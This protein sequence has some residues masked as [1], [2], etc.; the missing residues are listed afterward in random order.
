MGHGAYNSHEISSE[1]EKVAW[2][3]A[4]FGGAFT[5]ISLALWL[6]WPKKEIVVKEVPREVLREV[7]REVPIEIIK[8]IVKP[9]EPKPEESFEANPNPLSYTR[10]VTVTVF[11]DQDFKEIMQATSLQMKAELKLRSLG[12]HVDNKTAGMGL[13]ELQISISALWT[14]ES[15]LQCVWSC[16]ADFQDMVSRLRITPDKVAHKQL[17]RA[18]TWSKGTFGIS[19]KNKIHDTFLGAVE[20][21]IDHFA[22]AYLEAN[23]K[24]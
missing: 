6:W 18:T 24:K 15:K 9:P 17:L 21:S 22:N 23:P 14:D 10:G 20:A 1:R 4:C 11:L 8:E 13:H 12:I 19:G 7:V 5:C 16:E 3:I 2:L